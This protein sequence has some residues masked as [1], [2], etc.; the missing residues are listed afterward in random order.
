MKEEIWEEFKKLPWWIPF[1]PISG[2][3]L[4]SISDPNS[5]ASPVHYWDVVSKRMYCAQKSGHKIAGF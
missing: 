5:R 4:S 2:R 3:G 1:E